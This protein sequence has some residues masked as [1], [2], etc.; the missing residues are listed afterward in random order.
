MQKNRIQIFWTV[1]ENHP[2]I[3]LPL[4]SSV[5]GHVSSAEFTAQTLSLS[6]FNGD[7]VRRGCGHNIRILLEQ[8]DSLEIVSFSD[9]FCV[10]N[11]VMSLPNRKQKWLTVTMETRQKNVRFSW[12]EQKEEH[13][14]ALRMS[15]RCFNCIKKS[16]SLVDC[17]PPGA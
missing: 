13:L 3:L 7:S 9:S 6:Y 17:I 11:Q 15:L 4:T 16:C 12:T 14:T 2:D 5:G 8:S 1:R 10:F